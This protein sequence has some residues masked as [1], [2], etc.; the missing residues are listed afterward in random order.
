MKTK[1]I[2]ASVEDGSPYEYVFNLYDL[3]EKFFEVLVN[4]VGGATYSLDKPIESIS[5]EGSS[6]F[7]NITINMGNFGHIH[8]DFDEAEKLSEGLNKM[9]DKLR[10]LLYIDSCRHQCVCG[11]I[12]TEKFKP[13]RS[14]PLL[15]KGKKKKCPKCGKEVN[16]GMMY[17]SKMFPNG[18]PK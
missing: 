15:G 13:T 17:L 5:I 7:E 16:G 1:F 12:W 14:R 6:G 2:E 4:Q 18:G 9:V 3:K 11:H 8:L 10:N